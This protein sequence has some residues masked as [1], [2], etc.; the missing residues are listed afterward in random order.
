M[1]EINE[2]VVITTYICAAPTVDCLRSVASERSDPNIRIG[3][4]VIDNASGDSASIIRDLVRHSVLWPKNRNMSALQS[5]RP[6]R[7]QI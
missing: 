4:Y 3:V 1:Q 2:A 5:F 6:P 7:S